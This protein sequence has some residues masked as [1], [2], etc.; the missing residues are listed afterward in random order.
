MLAAE[1][2]SVG[3]F[4]GEAIAD[5][6]MQIATLISVLTFILAS[7][8]WLG[9]LVLWHKLG[10]WPVSEAGRLRHGDGAPVAGD[11]Q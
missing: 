1:A 6:L 2:E 4:A 3:E 5:P 7:E 9:V 10:V 11:R 8:S